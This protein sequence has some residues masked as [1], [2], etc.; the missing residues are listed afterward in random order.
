[1]IRYGAIKGSGVIGAKSQA[2]PGLPLPLNFACLLSQQ[3]GTKSGKS[4]MTCHPLRMTPP[5]GTG[6]AHTPI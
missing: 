3:D 1:M 5:L 2:C 6:V 4:P